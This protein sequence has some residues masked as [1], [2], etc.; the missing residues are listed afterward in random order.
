MKTH[1]IQFNPISKFQL[2]LFNKIKTKNKFLEDGDIAWC[3][4]DNAK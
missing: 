1:F 3:P 4:L 2:K